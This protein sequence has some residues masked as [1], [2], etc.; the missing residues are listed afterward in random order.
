M[1]LSPSILQGCDTCC[2]FLEALEVKWPRMTL[3]Q[4]VYG[5]D[6]PAHLHTTLF[7]VGSSDVI[8]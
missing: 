8:M 4:A 1:H 7:R 3:T 5:A 6:F 2:C